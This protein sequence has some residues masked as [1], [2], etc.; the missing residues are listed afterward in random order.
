MTREEETKEAI[1]KIKKD[2][3]VKTQE[4]NILKEIALSLAII[5]DVLKEG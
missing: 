2:Y 5:A 3:M 1:E 4:F